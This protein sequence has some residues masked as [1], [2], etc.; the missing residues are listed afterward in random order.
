MKATLF[1]EV[2]EPILFGTLKA[3]CG[4]SWRFKESWCLSIAPSLDT[5]EYLLKSHMEFIAVSTTLMMLRQCSLHH[6]LFP[7]EHKKENFLI[8]L[9]MRYYSWVSLLWACGFCELFKSYISLF[10]WTA[11]SSKPNLQ[12]F[13]IVQAF[14][15]VQAVWCAFCVNS[16]PP[17]SPEWEVSPVLWVLCLPSSFHFFTSRNK[18]PLCSTFFSNTPVLSNTQRLATTTYLE[19]IIKTCAFHCSYLYPSPPE[20][21]SSHC[22]ILIR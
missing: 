21:E 11:G 7:L 6:A 22:L 15:S 4:L 5:E 2:V 10:D 13:M 17:L 19:I 1:T 8:L 12:S 18:K 16:F 14:M 9:S 3:C 20:R